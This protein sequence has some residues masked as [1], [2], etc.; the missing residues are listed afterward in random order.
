MSNVP[1]RG[2]GGGGTL[3]SCFPKTKV[4]DERK[5]A[6][7]R[8]EWG[9]SPYSHPFRPLSPC[10]KETATQRSMTNILQGWPSITWRLFCRAFASSTFWVSLPLTFSIPSGVINLL[11]P[12][13]RQP[14]M[15]V[16]PPFV[17]RGFV[18]LQKKGK[19]EGDGTDGRTLGSTDMFCHMQQ[20]F[21]LIS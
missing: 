1:L 11:P 8:S 16:R 21:P 14:S 4:S 9:K 2:G 15:A 5:Y 6:M 10:H 18:S 7:R 12:P 19:T 13:D 17:D 20:M 3:E